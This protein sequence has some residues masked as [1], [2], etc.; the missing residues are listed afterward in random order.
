MGV[1]SCSFQEDR[2]PTPQDPAWDNYGKFANFY[3]QIQPYI[4]SLAPAPPIAGPTTMV[5]R[6]SFKANWRSVCG[7]IGY[8]L[9]VATDNSFTRYVP[10][11]QNLAVGNVTSRSVTGLNPNTTYYYRVRARNG[12][13]ASGNSNVVHMATA[14]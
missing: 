3:P 10:G 6:N 8:R 1:L 11:Y 12:N 4:G 9:D 5:T 7:A 2:C 13:G 14:R